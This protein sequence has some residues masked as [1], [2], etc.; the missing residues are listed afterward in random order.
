[1]DWLQDF[2]FLRPYWLLALILPFTIWY[3]VMKN[4]T[5]QSSWAKI[6]DEHLLNFLLIKGQNKQRKLPYILLALIL[7]LTIFAIAGPTWVKKQNPALSVDN[8]VMIMI[9]MSTDMWAKDVSP[10]RIVRAELI[11]RDLLENFNSTESGLLVY[12]REPFVISPLTED[13]SLLENLLLQLDEDVLPE[14]GDRLDRAID[15]AVG[16]MK[17]SGY[18][19]GNMIVLTADVGERFD[20]AL[21]SAAKA[22][23]EGFEVNII[24]ISSDEN[25]K[26]AMIADK[27]HGIYLDYQQNIRTLT[28]KINSIYS[29]ELKQSEN[30][31][32][33]WEDMGYYLFWLPAFLLLY[34]F[35]KGVLV[36]FLL[37]YLST[38]IAHAG[39]FLNDNQEAKKAF[40]NHDYAEA[41]LKFENEDWKA[42]AL[43]KDGKYE[44]AY[45]SYA[46]KD[47]VTSL[48]NQGNALAK[49]GKISEAIKKYEQVLEQNK[50]FE[51]ARF[52]LEY[53]KKMQQQ[54]NQDNNMNQQNSQNSQQDK[55]QEQ[56]QQNK[57][58]KEE[59]AQQNEQ[60]EQQDNKKNEQSNGD[61]SDK[62]NADKEQHQQPQ[63]G[64][65]E[66]QQKQ[67]SAQQNGT[68]KNNPDG[69]GNDDEESEDNLEKQQNSSKADNHEDENADNEVEVNKQ[70]QYGDEDDKS[71]QLAKSLQTQAGA[72]SSDDKEKIR[73]RLQKFRD[74]PEDKGGLLRA[75]IKKEYN[76]NRYNDR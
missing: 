59:Q 19:K 33:V 46:R 17:K 41:A 22:G 8:P 66:R 13:V 34:Y 50:D 5:I 20:A 7:S 27:G 62:Q 43:Y 24:K 61:G 36:S 53:L 18:N 4:D 47:D 12:S 31:Q 54:Q 55:K 37:L 28:E 58:N 35:R 1:M 76:L 56:S 67:D 30:M 64:N 9:N 70:S 65:D 44:E 74:I 60:S 71:E 21:E 11:A 48:Y 3:R 15:L 38:S 52:N 2:H 26:L 51:D 16:R 39:W 10:S 63:E 45:K 23:N 42:A 75:M 40:D 14:N 68:E 32:T 6:C 72:K 29:K 25:E 73:A 49:S 57:N 69:K